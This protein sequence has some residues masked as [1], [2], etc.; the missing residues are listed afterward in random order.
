MLFLVW[1][2]E[3]KKYIISN[4][5]NEKIPLAPNL[6]GR[7]LPKDCFEHFGYVYT[8]SKET[9][10]KLK[11]SGA[12]VEKIKIYNT[13]DLNPDNDD[14]YHVEIYKVR[15]RYYIMDGDAIWNIDSFEFCEEGG[16]YA[17]AM[18]FD[19]INLKGWYGSSLLQYTLFNLSNGEHIINYDSD[20]I[21]QLLKN[22]T[23]KKWQREIIYSVF[24]AY[25][26]Y[27]DNDL[28]PCEV[29]N[30]VDGCLC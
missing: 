4:Y 12:K 30:N 21:K 8:L 2:K 24:M 28:L 1:S 23:F 13:F 18:M 26:Y 25:K 6:F 29:C 9:A 22:S 14:F 17:R 15:G 16:L 11:E 19:I 10:K 27:V 3:M 5:N 20:D 7:L